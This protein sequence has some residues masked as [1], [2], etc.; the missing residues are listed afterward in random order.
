MASTALEAELLAAIAPAPIAP[1]EPL[2]RLDLRRQRVTTIVWATGFTR[3]YPW[4]RVPV[5][6]ARGE[7]VQRRGVTPEPGLYVLGQRFQ[8]R[9]DSNFIDGVRHDA[10]YVAGHIAARRHRAG[11]TLRP[12]P[13]PRMLDDHP[14]TPT[15]P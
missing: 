10:A 5:L 9:L 3:S 12:T 15:L 6:D 8:H 2:R 4:L 7:I 14:P 11:P 13:D 1:I